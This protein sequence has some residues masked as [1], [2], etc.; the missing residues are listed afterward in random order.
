LAN[1]CPSSQTSH[2][3]KVKRMIAHL[4]R[5]HPRVRSS[6]FRALSNIKMDYLLNR[7]V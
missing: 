3:I 6:V 1:S 7:S 2:R 5:E 4:E